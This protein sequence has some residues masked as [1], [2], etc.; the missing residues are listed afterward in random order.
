[1]YFYRI[2][3]DASVGPYN[4]DYYHK[5]ID[6]W[7][8]S[9]NGCPDPRNDVLYNLHGKRVY[10]DGRDWDT[11]YHGHKF[12]FRNLKELQAWFSPNE[13]SRLYNIG[14]MIKRVK[15]ELIAYSKYQ[16]IFIPE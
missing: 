9:K 10:Y 13:L 1:M 7:Y 4:S 15:G 8:K 12:G 5:W 2:E 3:N 14:F 6:G 11:F 16:C